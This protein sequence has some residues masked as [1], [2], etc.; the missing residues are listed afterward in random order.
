[1]T[2]HADDMVLVPQSWT[3]SGQRTGAR[4]VRLGTVKL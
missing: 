2:A 1:M 3:R 4:G